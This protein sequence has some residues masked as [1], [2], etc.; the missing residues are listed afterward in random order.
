MSEEQLIAAFAP[1]AVT[2]GVYMVV[3][4]A[5]AVRLGGHRRNGHPDLPTFFGAGDFIT[6][7]G[8]VYSDGHR[9]LGD[10]G[11]SALV[12]IVRVLLVTLAPVMVGLVALSLTV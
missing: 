5:L 6:S 9:E 8:W 12:W 1:L 11:T 7:V 2:L 3:V 4:M 10:G